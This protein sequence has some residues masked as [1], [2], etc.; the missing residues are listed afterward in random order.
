MEGSSLMAWTLKGV[1]FQFD[2]NP[3]TVNAQGHAAAWICPRC[4]GPMLFVYQAGG[5]GSHIMHLSTCPG[6]GSKYY[7]TPPHGFLPDPPMDRMPTS[8]MTIIAHWVPPLPEQ[9]DG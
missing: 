5:A 2:G 9:T 4:G 3:T 6:C 1:R 7:L 8:N